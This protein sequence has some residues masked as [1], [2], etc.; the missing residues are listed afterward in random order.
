MFAFQ[1]LLLPFKGVGELAGRSL[2]VDG[3]DWCVGP[4]VIN[5]GTG[6]VLCS[7]IMYAE[8]ITASKE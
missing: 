5:E 1:C 7:P 8:G 4:L 3:S 2:R 6:T